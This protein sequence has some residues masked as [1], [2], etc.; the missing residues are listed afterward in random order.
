MTSTL[1][2]KN[3]EKHLKQSQIIVETTFSELTIHLLGKITRTLPIATFAVKEG[4]AYCG[5]CGDDLTNYN[6]FLER[7]VDARCPGCDHYI[8]PLSLK[9][10]GFI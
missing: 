7:R 10:L 5:S 2:Q 1:E 3:F 6:P 8:S 4:H 9:Q